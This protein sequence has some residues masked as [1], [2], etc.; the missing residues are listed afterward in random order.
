ML[1]K[2]RDVL[3]L[4]LA[5]QGQVLLFGFTGR[6]V[7]LLLLAGAYSLV[8]LAGE[9]AGLSSARLDRKIRRLDHQLNQLP[10]RDS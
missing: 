7:L 8:L 1:S 5:F 3:I 4:W 6:A 9:V 2:L 10:G